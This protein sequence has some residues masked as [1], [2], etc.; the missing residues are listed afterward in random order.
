MRERGRDYYIDNPLAR[1]ERLERRVKALEEALVRANNSLMGIAN[2]NAGP[3]HIIVPQPENG[4][5]W[6]IFMEE[7]DGVPRLI[8]QEL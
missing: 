2:V 6:E 4:G 7:I 5:R 1:I 3:P 8:G